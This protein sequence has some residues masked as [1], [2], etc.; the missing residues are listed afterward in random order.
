MSKPLPAESILA[1]YEA[2]LP[3]PEIA[4]QIGASRSGV[5]LVLQR[6]RQAGRITGYKS[7]SRPTKRHSALTDEQ[8][9]IIDGLLLGDGSISIGKTC[10]NAHLALRSIQQQFIKNVCRLLAPIAFHHPVFIPA[11]TQTFF[12]GITAY[13]KDAFQLNSLVDKALTP[14]YTRW[15]PDG[16]K[17]VPLD[18]VIT[19][20]TMLYW[21]YGDGS[22]TCGKTQSFTLSTQGFSHHECEFLVECIYQAC[23]IRFGCYRA[24]NYHV[25]GL[26]RGHDMGILLEWMLAGRNPLPC[27][28]YKW[29]HREPQP[30]RRGSDNSQARLS[31]RDIYEI[32]ALPKRGWTHQMIAE[33][34][35]VSRSH[36]RAI[37]YGKKWQH[38]TK[39]QAAS[40]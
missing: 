38:I 5:C 33:C 13:C 30:P 6:Y 40:H 1:H 28:Q 8:Y 19:P 23:G 31:E 22:T 36:V 11:H 37:I 24:G 16:P 27:F 21:F 39:E 29:K 10:V 32:L 12:N 4:A 18:L 15:R 34:F 14:V 25:L 20:A 35:A 3:V 2:G 7:S 17:I 26:A 9:Q